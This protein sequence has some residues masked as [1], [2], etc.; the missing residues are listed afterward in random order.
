MFAIVFQQVLIMFLLM[1]IGFIYAKATG[2]RKEECNRICNI[3]LMI[4][5]PCLLLSNLQRPFNME[6]VEELLFSL[7]L[8]A[9]ATWG[10]SEFPWSP[11]FSVR[12]MRCL[13]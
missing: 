10:L 6:I 2:M 4:V 7:G 3:L 8:A 1:L 13:P 9:L 12:N 5:T 11:V